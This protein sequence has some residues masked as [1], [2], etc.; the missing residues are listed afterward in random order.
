MTLSGNKGANVTDDESLRTLNRPQLQ[1]KFSGTD[2]VGAGLL[3]AR[4]TRNV[5]RSG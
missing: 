4:L 5:V 3:A 2:F 1:S